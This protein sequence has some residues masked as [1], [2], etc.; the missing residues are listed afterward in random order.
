MVAKVRSIEEARAGLSRY[1]SL[2][3]LW[4]ASTIWSGSLNRFL[5][6]LMRN[7]VRSSKGRWTNSSGENSVIKAKEVAPK[8]EAKGFSTEKAENLR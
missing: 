1:D 2:A 6:F 3:V 7:R 4:R 8:R 5:P